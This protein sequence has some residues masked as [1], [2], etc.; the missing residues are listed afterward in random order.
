MF[1]S[2]PHRRYVIAL[3]FFGPIHDATWAL[4]FVDR[5]G[6]VPSSLSPLEGPDGITLG[7][8]LYCL[9]FA[10]PTYIGID[11]TM[12]VCNLTGAV[13]HIT[14]TGQ[15]PT[16]EKERSIKRIFEIVRLLHSAPQ[17][18][19]RAT[20]VWLVRRKGRYYVLKD[21]WPLE[22]KPFSEIRH[23][24]K[25]NQTILNDTNMHDTLKHTYPV[26]VVGQELYDST[27]IRRIEL[28]WKPLSRV[29]RRIVTKHLGDPLTSFRNKYEL[30]S[31]L[32]DVVAC[33][34]GYT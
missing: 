32:C 23:L 6:V 19:G 17:V 31:V 25:I 21:S 15:T 7:Q 5:S 14:V 30:C 28:P 1:E 34:W 27:D 24:L 13:T 20:R 4:V 11:E 29:H 16:S 33:K 9:S 12:T 18:S 3:A 22:S 8:V 2:Q 26:L 10:R